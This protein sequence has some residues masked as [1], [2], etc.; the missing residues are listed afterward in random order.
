VNGYADGYHPTDK[1][2]RGQMSAFVARSIVTPLGDAGLA[3]YTP[4]ALPT[5]TDVPTTFA[6]YKCIEYIADPARDITHGYGDGLYHPERICS[7]AMMAVY[8]QRAF[9]LPL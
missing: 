7:R 9:E 3:S 5:F 8:V 6:Y 2:N 1:V 4:P